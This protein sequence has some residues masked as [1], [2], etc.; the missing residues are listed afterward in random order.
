MRRRDLLIGA[1]S[2]AAL[3]GGAA[4]AF[5]VVGPTDGNAVAPVELDA[6]EA[7]G[8]DSGT[9]TVPEPGRVTFLELFA[10]WCNVCE[11]M[12]PELAAVHESVGDG[13]Q[14]LSVTN[15][16]LGN[17]VTREDVA[18]WWRQHSGTWTVAADRDLELTQRLDASGVPYSFVLDAR[19]RVVW[20]HRGRTSAEKIRAGIR[21]AGG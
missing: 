2:L 10:T 11:S 18:A 15:E 9:V 20:Q 6:I 14:F 8:S 19:N 21:T 1:G 4:V 12:M 7:P 17:T 13:V 3:G 16:P 5:D